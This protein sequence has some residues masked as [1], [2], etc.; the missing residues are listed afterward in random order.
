MSRRAF[1]CVR[2]LPSGRWQARYTGPHLAEHKAPVTFA[3]KKDAESWLGAEDRLIAGG[4]WVAP[5]R[6]QAAASAGAVTVGDY[7]ERIIQ[8][9]AT[10]SRKPM[11]PTT[12]D[13]YR[14][15]YRLELQEPFG[16]VQLTALTPAMVAAWVDAPTKARTQKGRAYDLLK[17]VLNDA[18]EE[19]LIEKNPCRVKGAG[20]PPPLARARC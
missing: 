8:R 1:G 10:R 15:D 11:A 17:S 14:K 16:A 9:R 20:N 19:E 13:L 3:F 12:A 7:V 5:A 2:K 4:G 18:V 6:R